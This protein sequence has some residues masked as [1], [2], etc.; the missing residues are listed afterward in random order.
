[1][2]PYVPKRY[3]EEMRGLA[4][5]AG[6]P[7][8][9][10]ERMHALPELTAT[11]CSSFAVA[12]Q[13][14]T[15]GRLIQIRNLD[16]AIQSNVQKHAALLVYHPDEGKPFVNVGWLGFIGV[17]SG[18]SKDGLSVA[19][20]GA[21]SVDISL[22]GIPMPFL[23]RKV[24]EESDSLEEAIDLVRWSRRTV[25]YNYLFAHAQTRNA[26]ALETTRTRFA[27]FW[28]GAESS[29]EYAVRLDNALFRSDFALDPAVRD[30][31]LACKGK[32][33]EPGLES[34]VESSAYKVRYLGQG[35]LLMQFKDRVDSEVAIAIASAVA[36]SSNVQSVVY[37]YPE[38]WFANAK[39]TDPAA[40]QVYRSADIPELFESP[41]HDPISSRE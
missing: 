23:L 41:L 3:L 6:I 5:G 31:Q 7:L 9:T 26:V 11:S 8:K 36:P 1:M 15:D 4:K 19:E 33:S 27:S 20:I 24:L 22:D 28:Q 2:E 13:M 35:Q 32:P 37:A 21:E 16:W 14:T 25:G 10:L 18:I 40:R 38:L 17:I 39:G 12:N 29:S 30:L 34:P